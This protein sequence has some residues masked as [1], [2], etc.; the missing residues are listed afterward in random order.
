MHHTIY[1]GNQWSKP[2]CLNTI[3]SNSL[4]GCDSI[5]CLPLLGDW[6]CVLVCEWLEER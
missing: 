1:N 3:I 6:K 4:L 2:I 5:P